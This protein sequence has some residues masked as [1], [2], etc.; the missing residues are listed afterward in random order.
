MEWIVTRLAPGVWGV[1][2]T[3]F[4]GSTLD[5]DEGS[6]VAARRALRVDRRH[7]PD[8][9]RRVRRGRAAVVDRAPRGA[10][11]PWP[12]PSTCRW[13]SGATSLG[14]APVIEE[15]LV[16][17]EA[18]GRP[19]SPPSWCRSTRRGRTCSARTCAPCTRPPA[20]R[21]S[22]RTTRRSAASRSPADVLAGALARPAVR[23]RG[24]GRGAA[25]AA[26]D[27]D[28]D[29][30][31]GRARLRRARRHRPAR[32]AGRRL[33]RRD[34]RLLLPGGAAGLRVGVPD[35]VATRRPARR[36]CPTC[37]WSTSSSRCGSR[38]PSAR[39][40]CAGAG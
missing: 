21:S 1:V 38:S 26:G 12:T 37:R 29:R 9:A 15:A 20:C 35:R 33:G 8:R 14:T 4:S 17:V 11:R 7:R 23:R 2:A 32:R 27:R 40:R 10:A 13:W 6:L 31:A 34:D 30:A 22:C 16:A 5:V 36:S 3:P 24:Q 39:R 19:A 28:A 25:H 18:V